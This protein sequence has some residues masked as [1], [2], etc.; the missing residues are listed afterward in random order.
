MSTPAL[1]ATPYEEA[2][3][4][5]IVLHNTHPELSV[6]DVCALLCTSS[7]TADSA[8]HCVSLT[9]S[10]ATLQQAQ[11]FSQWLLK[12]GNLLQSLHFAPKL[13]WEPDPECYYGEPGRIP[14]SLRG[15]ASASDTHGDTSDAD[16]TA[17]DSSAEDDSYYDE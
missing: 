15:D 9:F 8:R 6:R 16:S 2:D 1:A 3:V 13:P 11:H 7:T 12:N 4:L 10:P 5:D 17:D 14:P